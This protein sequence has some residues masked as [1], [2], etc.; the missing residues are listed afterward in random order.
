MDNHLDH[1]SETLP[2]D[3]ILIRNSES[4]NKKRA[5][6]VDSFFHNT[7]VLLLCVVINLL[8]IITVI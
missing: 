1:A 6:L 7:S 5:D 4:R 8:N 2:P 3:S